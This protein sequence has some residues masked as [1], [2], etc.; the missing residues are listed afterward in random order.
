[1]TSTTTILQDLHRRLQR[2]EVISNTLPTNSPSVPL[3]IRL[4]EKLCQLLEPFSDSSINTLQ[5]LFQD[6][7]SAIA[8]NSSASNA[9]N[10]LLLVPPPSLLQQQRGRPPILASD[11]QDQ[12]GDDED[13]D[14][15]EEINAFIFAASHVI[16]QTEI[17]IQDL[18]HVR[19][20]SVD[21]ESFMLKDVLNF[22]KNDQ[23]I[24]QTSEASA[25]A[26][27]TNDTFERT[28]NLA[29]RLEKLQ[30]DEVE[31]VNEVKYRLGKVRNILDLRSD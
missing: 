31:F 7:K 15:G 26:A 11:N 13:D 22:A 6:V 30:K 25:V 27:A 28:Q 23:G 19:E 5:T 4:S 24:F 10:L 29:K 18:L 9:K 14:K 20:S 8:K 3:S 21:K 1:M 12:D 2:I 16:Q 17:L